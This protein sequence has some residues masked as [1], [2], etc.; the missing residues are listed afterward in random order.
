MVSPD[1]RDVATLL[2]Y[3]RDTSPDAVRAEI[4]SDL[5]CGVTQRQRSLYY[6][7][8]YGCQPLENYPSGIQFMIGTRYTIASWVARRN[9]RTG[10]GSGSTVDRRAIT[11]QELI[12]IVGDDRGN[13]QVQVLAIPLF[14]LKQR[15]AVAV[16]M[17]GG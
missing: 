14:D 15:V 10:D 16:P 7:R 1:P 12:T 9:R 11:S 8:S 6:D 3:G 17:G 4:Q 2:N 5:Y 13:V